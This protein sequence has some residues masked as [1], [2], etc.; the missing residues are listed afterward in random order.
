MVMMM[1]K[2]RFALALLAAAAAAV[3]AEEGPGRG[4]PD[5]VKWRG[6]EEGVAEAK[7]T[8]RPL[9]VLFHKP[10][11]G[12]CKGLKASIAQ[13]PAEFVEL[14]R[15]FVMVN[16]VDERVSLQPEWQPDGGYIPRV[17]WADPATAQPKK[18]IV[19]PESDRYKH[20][21]HDRASLVAGMR[22]ALSLW[23]LP[24]PAEEV[25]EE[26]PQP[27]DQQQQQQQPEAAEQV[28]L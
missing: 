6:F 5:A 28:E 17:V 9:M 1:M 4:F 21:F 2:L 25:V 24:P 12:A 7:E 27:M 10:W 22:S 13:D 18:T 23:P 3:V 15:G 26:K 11:C 16:V 20:F 14:A 19:N 8:G